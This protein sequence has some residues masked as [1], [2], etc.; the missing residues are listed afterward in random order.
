MCGSSAGRQPFPAHSQGVCNVPT[1]FGTSYMRAH[2]MRNNNQILYGSQ[3]RCE[4]IFFYTGSTK[5]ADAP[6][7]CDTN[8]LVLVLPLH[9]Y[10]RMCRVRYVCV[11]VHLHSRWLILNDE[12]LLSCGKKSTEIVCED[13]G[14]V[15][16]ILVVPRERGSDYDFR[17]FV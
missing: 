3:T 15:C 13:H 10:V 8:V 14:K 1:Y 6:S 2:S 9:R 4:E 11:R 16:Q 5:D 12:S 17:S 7:V